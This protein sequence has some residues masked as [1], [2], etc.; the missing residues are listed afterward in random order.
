MT[1]A[2][3][4]NIAV[5]TGTFDPVHR[6][7]LDIISRG[8]K[9][10][11][12]LVVGVGTN[13][14]KSPFFDPEERVELIR[15]VTA[16][17]RNVSV[18]SFDTL[19]VQFVREVGA[20]VMLRGLRT[21]SDMES[22][23]TMSLMNLALDPEIETVF[24]MANEPFSHVSGTLLRQVA[25]FGGPLDKFLPPVVKEALERRVRERALKVSP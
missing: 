8:S 24:L 16:P 11:E 13:P 14:E 1:R 6:G 20:G 10:F 19:A 22:E 17:Y 5:Y 15:K 25:T 3:N 9:I 23:F 18:R 21:T 2:L 12:Q 4:H 7:H